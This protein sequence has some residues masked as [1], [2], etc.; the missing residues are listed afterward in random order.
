MDVST[1]PPLTVSVERFISELDDIVRRL[2][3]SLLSDHPI[4]AV[5]PLA[6]AFQLT[7]ALIDV[8]GMLTDEEL[9]AFARCF[10]RHRP[11]LL[12]L[13]PGD[14][15]RRGVF[16]GA[17]RWLNRPSPLFEALLAHDAA[18][19]TAHAW[20]Y[21]D[22][23]VALAQTVASLDDHVSHV[24]LNA[25]EGLRE[26]L[27]QRLR[28][29]G[30]ARPSPTGVDPGGSVPRITGIGS[31]DT[32]SA[33]DVLAEM[34]ELIGLEGV[35]RQMR[36]VSDLV[37][38][39]RLR[40]QRG[41]PSPVVSHHMAFVGNPGTGKTTVARLVARLYRSLGVLTSG[42]LVETD[43]A[44]LVAGYMGQTAAR[45]GEAVE[46]ALDG[47]LLID[48]AYSLTTTGSDDAYGREAVDA[49]V[50][51]MEDNR[52]RLV[53]IVT[54]YPAEMESFLA[55]NPGLRSRF[56]RVITFEDYDTDALVEIF[57]RCARDSGYE[58]TAPALRRFAVLAD[59]L[60]RGRGFGNGRLARRVFE[61]AVERHASRLMS[62]GS[63]TEED[64]VSLRAVD[65]PDSVA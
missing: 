25:I 49:L 27:G 57:Q 22:L 29:A 44:G 61:R 26:R 16:R 37:T 34:D 56:G 42:H 52:D 14:M 50:K 2:P 8:D 54:G 41:L 5:G 10:S 11:S 21:H 59:S 3:P 48:E 28:T 43:R 65:L 18:R 19:G 13:T 12:N 30:V 33:E 55:S 62:G 53:V 39:G 35:K 47:V 36:L 58:P 7:R 1:A 20:R 40:R 15:R 32:P 24:E 45:V 6:D 51:R 9:S 38:V 46:K 64:L 23:A 63:P 4:E 60:E 31:D 17:R